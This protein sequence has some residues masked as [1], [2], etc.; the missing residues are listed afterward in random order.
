MQDDTETRLAERATDTVL[1]AVDLLFNSRGGTHLVVA[2]EQRARIFRADFLQQLAREEI[3]TEVRIEQGLEED[4]EI[5]IDPNELDGR[6]AQR[7]ITH[8]MEWREM[9]DVALIQA[10][11]EMGDIQW[12]N[13][14]GEWASLAQRLI[15]AMPD[16]HKHKTSGRA[17][18][19]ATFIE[20]TVAMLKEEGVPAEAINKAYRHDLSSILAPL[21]AAVTHVFK[22]DI[23]DK[24]AEYLWCLDQAATAP[25]LIDFDRAVKD[26]YRDPNAPPPPMILYSTEYSPHS[27]Y[28]RLA[29]EMPVELWAVVQKRLADRLQEYPG[30]LFE[31]PSPGLVERALGPG[32]WTEDGQRLMRASVNSNWARSICFGILEAQP[33]I[34][35]DVPFIRSITDLG[36]HDVTTAMGALCSIKQDGTIPFAVSNG[37]Q[38][39]LA[40]RTQ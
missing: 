25:T 4:G 3:I 26:R 29:S 20:T 2:P 35:L 7:V 8:V 37:K 23:E 27:E 10:A 17:R 12:L 36:E 9:L 40:V 21:N 5:D 14:D 13:G 33:G 34:W 18:Q 22:S 6:V 15:D 31:A 38:W 24:L 28:V 11:Q 1:S 39:R 30:T 16:E 32:P 19:M